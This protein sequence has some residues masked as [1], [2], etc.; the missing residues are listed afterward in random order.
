MF[1]WTS[2]HLLA[3]TAP[4]ID[5]N[6]LGTL[7]GGALTIHGHNLGDKASAA[8]AVHIDSGPGS[9]TVDSTSSYVLSWQPEQIELVLPQQAL[10][11]ALTVTVDGVESQPV[12]LRVY[13]YSSFAIPPSLGTNK[14]GLTLDVGPDGKVWLNQ[15]FHLELKSFDPALGTFMARTFPQAPGGGIFATTLFGNYR[16]RMSGMGEDVDT[17]GDG[18][19]WFTEGGEML[20]PEGGPYFNTSR[21]VR[22]HPD[23]DT[24]DCYNAP[25][26][27]AQ[28]IGVLVDPARNM[29]WYT[30]GGPAHGAAI[31]GFSPDSITSDCRFD[32]YQGSKR[33]ALCSAT[34]T[35]SC[36]Q[37][38]PLPNA[39]SIPSHLVLDPEGNIWFAEFFGNKIGRLSPETGEILELPLPAPIADQGPGQILG[40]SGPWEM[41][42]DDNGDVWAT[43]FFDATVI[44]IHPSLMQTND[45]LHLDANGLNPC[46]ED[47]TV[48]YDDDVEKVIHTVAVG[49]EGLVWF[50]VEEVP[51]PANGWTPGAHIGFMSSNGGQPVLLPQL[52]GLARPGGIAQDLRTHDVWFVEAQGQR[53]GRLQELG[54]GDADGDGFSDLIDTCVLVPNESQQDGDMDGLGNECDPDQC[55]DFD[56]DGVITIN[57][58]LIP[59][60]HYHAAKP[61]GGLYGIGDILQAMARYQSRCERA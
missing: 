50:G 2:Q 47:M 21:I 48:Q 60:R 19:V 3:G 61:D 13:H 10:S 11:G 27:N 38:F 49:A 22:Y 33:D 40:S 39:F 12:K 30:E 23:T 34:V 45:C 24:F 57:D 26:D 52:D 16:S 55:P 56:H 41:A 15:E 6:L 59:V 20:Y 1:T 7:D 43:E 5:E 4:N 18:N 9:V 53:V 28:A 54:W 8:R 37:R 36:H 25:V 17:D 58:I 46:V 42:A 32:P 31:T 51:G 44:R 29:V 14:F 35:V